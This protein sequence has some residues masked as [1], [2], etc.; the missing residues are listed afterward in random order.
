MGEALGALCS[1][2][3]PA[4]AAPPGE[5][6]EPPRVREFIET[7]LLPPFSS[8]LD[9][10]FC[11]QAV[12]GLRAEVFA[13]AQRGRVPAI[14]ALGLL[15]DDPED[16]ARALDEIRRRGSRWEAE[17][18]RDG[19]QALAERHGLPSAEAL[20]RKL[21]LALAWADG[22][23]GSR[24]ARVWWEIGGHRV[25]LQVGRGK[26][27]V[28]AYGPR[29]PRSRLPEAVRKA[30]AFG[31]VKAVRAELTA[32]YRRLREHLEE[33]MAGRQALPVADVRA[34]LGNPVFANLASRLVLRLSDGPE[35][36]GPEGEAG[37]L[38]EA[39]AR[40]GD[41]DSVWVA[42][43]QELADDGSL[44][45]WQ[46]QIV[47]S[48]MVQPFKQ[49]FRE[50]YL[51]DSRELAGTRSPRF[52]GLPV[53]ARRAFALL[54]QRR[55]HPGRGDAARER[56]AVN[57]RAHIVWATESDDLG[58]RLAGT[59]QDVPVTTGEI[60]FERLSPRGTEVGL[61]E[62]DPVIFS[63]TL[64][65]ADLVVSLAAAGEMGLPSRQT[66]AIRASLVRRL[67]RARGLWH[68]CVAADDVH[69]IIQGRRASYRVHLGSGS[70]LIEE[71]GRHLDLRGLES[72]SKSYLPSE[73][74]DSRTADILRLVSL[75]SEDH[76]IES[77]F[78]LSQVAGG[79]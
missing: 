35:L 9:N 33:A 28:V 19:L 78:F 65:D 20:Q 5:E 10:L 26:V 32:A 68:V 30:E 58:R 43:P 27:E 74:A 71:S 4:G 23:L 49:C 17:A 70:V 34:L 15:E 44:G 47:A 11:V 50:F 72:P 46:D 56:P 8:M 79:E 41:T 40:L 59:R 75:L 61:S 31:E 51:A 48:R 3:C 1:L 2:D 7:Y 73:E 66:L 67:A 39:L 62:V 18:A 37:P 29:G 21:R 42:H 25:K 12:R 36:L 64:R 13:S 63:E 55:Y 6:H 57:L 22:G 76:K 16:T 38:T 14:R 69:V 52:A 53:H 54:R 45:R 60:Y 77:P 24:Q